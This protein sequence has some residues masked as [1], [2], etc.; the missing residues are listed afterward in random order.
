VLCGG[1]LPWPPVLWAPVLPTHWVSRRDHRP[2][3]L[4]GP[5]LD[6]ENSFQIALWSHFHYKQHAGDCITAVVGYTLSLGTLLRIC[7]PV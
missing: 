4:G 7:I 1:G 2:K 5:L 6:V 3:A